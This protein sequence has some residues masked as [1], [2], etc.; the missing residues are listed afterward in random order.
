MGIDN[1][2]PGDV[3]YNMYKLRK[4]SEIHRKKTQG[5]FSKEK[6]SWHEMK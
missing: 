3:F 2:C 5:M 6:K 1:R 4:W